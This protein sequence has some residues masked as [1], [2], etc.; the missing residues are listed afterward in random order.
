ML[1]RSLA[2]LL[3]CGEQM[4]PQFKK[5]CFLRLNVYPANRAEKLKT[6]TQKSI[7]EKFKADWRSF[8]VSAAF[9]LWI[10]IQAQARDLGVVGQTFAILEQ[11]LLAV[12]ETR[13]KGLNNTGELASHIQKIQ[14]AL[15]DKVKHPL[16]GAFLPRAKEAKT[17]TYNPTLTA[18]YDLKD[19]QG[20]IFHKAGA[21]I[22]PLESVSLSKELVFFNGDDPKQVSWVQDYMKDQK[23]LKL[24]LTQGAPFELMEKFERPVFFDQHG[25]LSK[26]LKL[27][28][29]P[30]AVKQQ[31]KKLV[32]EEIIIKGGQ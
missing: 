12:I 29:V 25:Y 7:W 23:P 3:R 8:V 6:C 4:T 31:G 22:N 10:C 2:E 18:P 5:S 15:E 20:K 19:H 13:L 11:D 17:Y 1:S 26:K 27:S 16:A 21:R 24:I 28:H 30:A 32:I 9:S 14:A